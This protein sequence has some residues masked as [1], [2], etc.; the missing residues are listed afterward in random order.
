MSLCC[1]D[2]SFWS[3][4]NKKETSPYFLWLFAPAFFFLLLPLYWTYSCDYSDRNTIGSEHGQVRKGQRDGEEHVTER[5]DK[6][7]RVGGQLGQFQR[8]RKW[9]QVV[10]YPS[11]HCSRHMPSSPSFSQLWNLSAARETAVIRQNTPHC[12]KLLLLV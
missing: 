12:Q 4:R 11:S 9:H 8:C 3:L 2:Y 5:R 7:D 1:R 10:V 6:G